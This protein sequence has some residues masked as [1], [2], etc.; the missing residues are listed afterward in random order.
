MIYFR[1]QFEGFSYVFCTEETAKELCS[2]GYRR[3]REKDVPRSVR[4]SA[5][6]NKIQFILPWAL[7]R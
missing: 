5:R 2:R 1:K 3:V 4:K 7:S 6:H